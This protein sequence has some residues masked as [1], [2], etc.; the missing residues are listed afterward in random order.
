MITHLFRD[1]SR[2][3]CRLHWGISRLNAPQKPEMKVAFVQTQR[4][5][6]SSQL[7]LVLSGTKQLLTAHDGYVD[8]NEAESEAVP[9]RKEVTKVMMLGSMCIKDMN[10]LRLCSFTVS[11]SVSDI[12][13]TMFSHRGPG[14]ALAFGRDYRHRPRPLTSTELQLRR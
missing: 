14:L 5:S 10:G 4:F 9:W 1:T 2:T 7:A 11:F 6:L 13:V 3:R 12:S 8:Q